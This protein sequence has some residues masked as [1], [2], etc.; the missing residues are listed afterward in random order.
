ME[1]DREGREAGTQCVQLI[2][3]CPKKL[4]K[5]HTSSVTKNTIQSI[6]ECVPPIAASFQHEPVQVI[7][8]VQQ[9]RSLSCS[10]W[11]VRSISCLA[12]PA[13]SLLCLFSVCHYTLQGP[14]EL[15]Y[16]TLKSQDTIIQLVEGAKDCG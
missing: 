8:L 7:T 13:L 6:N 4:Q 12:C 14:R 1:K 16:P 15:N 3:L 2:Q 10:Q 9:K 11:L 5:F